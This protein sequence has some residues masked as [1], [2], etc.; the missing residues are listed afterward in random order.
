MTIK[1]EQLQTLL[2]EAIVRRKTPGAAFALWHDG[3]LQSATSGVLN[4]ETGEPVKDESLF[5]IGSVTK[6]LT[7]TLIMQL[8]DRGLVE[9][10]LPVRHYLSDFRVADLMVTKNVT[11]RHLLN[12]TSGLGGDFMTDCG[13]GPDNLAR[14]VDRCALL[15]QVHPLNKGFSYCNTGFV[16]AGRII[17]VVTGLTYDE[18][19]KQFLFEPLGLQNA[20]SDPSDL[21]DRSVSAGHVPDPESPG[22]SRKLD[23]IYTIPTTTGPAGATPMMSAVDLVTF[24]RMHLDGGVDTGGHRILS[25]PSVATMQTP[26][27]DVP[28]PAR[29]INRWALGWFLAQGQGGELIG[30]DGATIGQC[31]YLRVHRETG[32][33]GALLV[34]GGAANDLMMDVFS[35]SFDQLTGVKMFPAPEISNQQPQD[36]SIY[37]GKYHSLGGVSR[38]LVK[39]GKLTV[40]TSNRI[41]D[42]LLEEAPLSLEYAGDHRFLAS[43]P[44]SEYPTIYGFLQPDAEGLPQVLFTGMRVFNRE[45]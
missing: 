25:E 39:E 21:V 36:L 24:A 28:V 38:V 44:G 2:D 31:A 32:T 9:L 14:Y 26:Q 30:H 34:N 4:V 35:R 33:I 19:L 20:A 23:T 42:L 3:T 12:H 6:V 27:V 18:A 43:R 13:S 22:D 16:I 29:D 11:V 41:D 17:E 15:T 7:A 40:A 10:D 5:Q 8:V 1:T 45:T 37:E